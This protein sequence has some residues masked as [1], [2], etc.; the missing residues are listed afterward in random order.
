MRRL[1]PPCACVLALVTA[2]RV[3]FGQAYVVFAPARSNSAW[4]AGRPGNRRRTRRPGILHDGVKRFFATGDAAGI[5]AVVAADFVDQ[6]RPPDSGSGREGLVIHL[7]AVRRSFPGLQIEP[8][9]VVGQGDTVAVRLEVAAGTT[10]PFLGMSATGVRPWG[11]MEIFRVIADEIV[12]RWGEPGGYGL[13][14]PIAT[15]VFP[16]LNMVDALP[17]LTRRSYEPG[18]SDWDSPSWG[19][20]LMVVES[21]TVI[22]DVDA[23]V[24]VT[25]RR[26]AD[27]R[28][29]DFTTVLPVKTTTPVTLTP[30]DLLTVSEPAKVETRNEAEA[31]AAVLVRRDSAPRPPS[32]A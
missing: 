26:A 32:H 13:F 18:A 7:G 24:V 31:P 27:A 1:I 22:V 14:A 23:I 19:P 30:G 28:D 16:G 4:N 9:E 11:S 10:A 25:V 21:G 29:G 2:P 17:T 12:A 15:E 3:W 6:S 20:V 8:V 5:R